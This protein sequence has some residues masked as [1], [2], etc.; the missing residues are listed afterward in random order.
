MPLKTRRTPNTSRTELPTTNEELAQLIFE[1]VNIV[2]ERQNADLGAGRR[3]GRGHPGS[4]GM[5]IKKKDVGKKPT[6]AVKRT[7]EPEKKP[8]ESKR[9]W[10]RKNQIGNRKNAKRETGKVYA[11]NSTE[12]TKYTGPL[13]KCN[14]GR[15]FEMN[16][17]N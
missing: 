11:S 8:V 14:R 13:P 15:A 12:P 17:R 2:L 10:T 1:H 4:E 9:K 3:K 5:L 7:E 16:A 6:E